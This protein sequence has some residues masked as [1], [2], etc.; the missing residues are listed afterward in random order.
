MA[1]GGT[2]LPH[3]FSR[4]ERPGAVPLIAPPELGRLISSGDAPVMV[5]IRPMAERSL[6]RLPNDR[7]I[8]LPELVR[9]YPTLPRERPV[10]I[11]DQYGSQARRAVEYLQR[12][13][14][15]FTAALEGGIDEYA[16]IVDP[17][18]PRY[19]SGARDGDLVLLQMPRFDSGCLAY[20]VADPVE[21]RAAMIDPGREV[22]PYL[23]ALRTGGWELAAILETHTHADHLAGHARLREKTDA[24]IFVSHRSPAQYPHERLAKGDYVA[25]GREAISVIE[26]PGHTAD[27]LTLRLRD[28]IF[29]GDT[30]LIGA[31]GRTD[32]GDGNP[33]QLYASLTEKILRL[34]DDTEVLPAHFGR[35]HALPERYSSTV[36][37]ERSTN[38][39]L[40]QGTLSAFRAYMTEGWPPKPSEFDRIVRENLEH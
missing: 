18:I 38:E 25:F 30:L 13:G 11:Y 6:A 28:K 3:P 37:F 32:L 40:L 14:L 1:I 2:D 36:G 29:T 5:D 31:C 34:P 19:R 12:K 21:R 23:E 15:A 24:P 39:A 27:H 8:P 7:H 26:T 16:R 35:R 9:E 33:D 4:P 22:E 20:L 10:V 17:S